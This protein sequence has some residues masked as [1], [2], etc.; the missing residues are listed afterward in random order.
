MT[1]SLGAHITSSLRQVFQGALFV[2]N[3]K[4]EHGAACT[5]WTF[6]YS[7]RSASTDGVQVISVPPLHA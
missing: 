5:G 4:G 2:V 1:D 7:V 3:A 6:A